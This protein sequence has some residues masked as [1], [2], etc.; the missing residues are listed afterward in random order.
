[1]IGDDT[2]DPRARFL[3]SL[4]HEVRTPLSGILGMTDLLLETKLDE[5]QMEYV[6]AARLCAENLLELL[7][8]TLE[9][10][11]LSAENI[12][13]DD[14]EFALR[15]LLESI[16]SEFDVKAR[17]K[18]LRL[19]HDFSPDL[20]QMASGDGLRLRQ[21]LVH[22]MA[23]AVKFTHRGV[24]EI[25]ASVRPV[26]ER[27]FVLQLRVADTGIGIPADQLH[28][29]FESFRQLDTGLSRQYSGLGLGLSLAQKIATL[30]NGHLSPSSKFGEGST[31][32]VEIP[33]RV[34]NEVPP[35]QPDNERLHSRI[36]VVEDNT[37]AR[38]IATEVLRRR[39]Y[40]VD[41]AASGEE[42]IASA[43]TVLYDLI[44]MDLQMPGMDGF[45]TAEAIRTL[46]PYSHVPI[47]AFTA[48]SSDEDRDASMR[49][50]LNGFLTKPVRAQEL[51]AA[52]ER[53]LGRRRNPIP[54][55]SPL[56]HLER[57]RQPGS[58]N[59]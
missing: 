54:I 52:I 48:N 10:S 5:E 56:A 41:C 57:T 50:G 53:H 43:N 45:E 59:L 25:G 51:T 26:S 58:P 49:R 20:P 9:Y 46:K 23:N 8:A 6:Q 11:A 18:G 33:L 38:T 31:F 24:V 30:M 55:S 22:L 7:N 32:R 28:S 44:L 1:M 13:L 12:Q 39:G 34:A 2:A 17:S 4:S 19:I 3:A 40:D 27:E 36:L 37:I 35:H 15:E 14:S 21:I 42:A 29:V 47:L 16:A